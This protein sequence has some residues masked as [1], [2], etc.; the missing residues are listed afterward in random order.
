L[1]PPGERYALRL[2]NYLL[3]ALLALPAGEP[4][5]RGSGGIEFVDLFRAEDQPGVACY[6]IPALVTTRNGTLIA[7]IDERNN[8]CADLRSNADINIVLR[9]SSDNG[10]TWSAIERIVDYP[11]GE[12]A[13]DPSLIVDRTTGEIFLFFNYMN[14]AAAPGEYY[15]RYVVSR[16]DGASWSAPVDITGQVARPA[17]KH[18][19]KFITSGR[20]TQ[21]RSGTLLHTLV[22]LD[23]GLH[24]FGSEDHGQSWFLIDTPIRPGDESKIIELTNGDW[25]INSRVNNSGLRYV[26]R[27]S[28]NGRT[29]TSAPDSTLVDPA[30][31]ASLL[32]Y[33]R[34]ADGF[35]KDRLLFANPASAHARENLS[36]W[37]SYDEGETWA[38]RKSI[39][40]ARSAYSSLCVLDTGAIGIFFEKDDYQTNVFARV[41]LDW[42]TDGQDSL[43]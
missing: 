11:Y 2:I 20:G 37:L 26:H 25:M 23:R 5:N 41:T 1:N 7:A 32:W 43:P 33:T 31:N 19:F 24:V 42:L 16:D 9:T 22:N 38:F 12:S 10:R 27:S 17:W 13:S 29:W 34:R 35:A 6:R 15:L 21:L 4:A 18:D 36:L 3:L 30:C 40:A 14:V 39:Y 8:S 28:D